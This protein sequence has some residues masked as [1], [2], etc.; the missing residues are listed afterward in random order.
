M[1]SPGL[2]EGVHTP[3]PHFRSPL[4]RLLNAESPCDVLC[5]CLDFPSCFQEAEGPA[6]PG[7][8]E[9]AS[10]GPWQLFLAPS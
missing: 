9:G 6:P 3:R 1:L 4:E 8:D 2:V 10:S 7:D 5:N